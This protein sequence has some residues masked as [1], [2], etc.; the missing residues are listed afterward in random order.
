[1]TLVLQFVD[2]AEDGTTTPIDLSA[3][4]DLAVVVTRPD[5]SVVAGLPLVVT[6]AAA[7]EA[8]IVFAAGMLDSRGGWRARAVADG[9]RSQAAAWRVG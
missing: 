5:A 1:M 9:Y 3:V 6:N 8:T 7:G 4:V 2:V